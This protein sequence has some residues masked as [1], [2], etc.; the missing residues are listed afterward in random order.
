[1]LGDAHSKDPSLH[2]I[3][4]RGEQ[5][6]G[7]FGVEV[8]DDRRHQDP[9]AD[10]NDRH[11]QGGDNAVEFFLGFE[12]GLQFPG[13]SGPFIGE[14][15]ERGGAFGNTSFQ[16][17]VAGNEGLVGRLGLGPCRG[18]GREGPRHHLRPQEADQRHD[19]LQEQGC[20]QNH[21]PGHQISHTLTC[22][23]VDL[24]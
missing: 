19:D 1:M 24:L 13:N 7:A 20:K 22:I 17:G 2:F 16:G 10:G 6:L 12:A 8:A 4:N 9:V 11:R 3:E 21:T 23:R 18:S 15:L 14:L 5:E